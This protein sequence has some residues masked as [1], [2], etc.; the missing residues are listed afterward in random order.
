MLALIQD[1]KEK[2]DK[3]MQDHSRLKMENEFLW[4]E[5][6]ELKNTVYKLSELIQKEKTAV[7]VSHENLTLDDIRA[8]SAEIQQVLEGMKTDIEYCLQKLSEENPVHV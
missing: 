2:L 4:K 7:T 5:N 8:L 1:L 3:L 6:A